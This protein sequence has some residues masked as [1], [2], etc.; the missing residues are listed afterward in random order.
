LA[1]SVSRFQP[2]LLV[3]FCKRLCNFHFAISPHFFQ[4]PSRAQPELSRKPILGRNCGLYV[5]AAIAWIWHYEL[6]TVKKEPSRIVSLPGARVA[7]RAAPKKVVMAAFQDAEVLDIT[8]PLDVFSIAGRVLSAGGAKQPPYSIKIVASRAGPFV[9][10]AGIKIVADYSFREI[11]SD[12]DTLMVPGGIGTSQAAADPA[13]IRWLRT[14]SSKARRVCSVCTGAFILAEAGLLDGRSA[15]TH[16]RWCDM[17]A[18]RYPAVSIQQDPIFVRDGK[19]FTSAGVTAGIDLALALVEEDLGRQVALATARLM[20]MFL[21]RPGG[22]SQFS[23]Q[24]SSQL[25]VREPIRELQAW[26]GE[27]LDQQLTV[28]AMAEKV[29]M[30]PR[31]FARV[32]RRETGMTPGNFVETSRVEAA[33]LRLE[34]STDAIEAIA[35]DCGFGTRE[36]MRRAFLRVLGVPPGS[37]R[38]RFR[39]TARALYDRA[40]H[41]A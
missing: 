25:A 40:R 17:L 36:S 29:A 13:L 41:T 22:Q 5:I 7:A 16:W 2:W 14:M 18:E 28:E 24:L 21:K 6:V 34:E 4:M 37:Y 8:G 23:A 12:V 33:R 10:S 1:W 35:A 11:Q 32:F 20:V 38:D 30:S 31:N 27:H 3:D 9:T 39:R 26:I 19:F 15:T